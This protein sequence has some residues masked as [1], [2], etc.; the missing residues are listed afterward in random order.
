M[1]SMIRR[2]SLGALHLC[3]AGVVMGAAMALIPIV[4]TVIE[5]FAPTITS[6]VETALDPLGQ[7]FGAFIA[8]AQR[9]FSI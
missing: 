5:C 9:E 2:Y 7:F 6:T 3:V 4:V 1:T 8:R